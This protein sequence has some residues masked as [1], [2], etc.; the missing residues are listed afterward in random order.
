MHR[1]PFR[2]QELRVINDLSDSDYQLL[3]DAALGADGDD[4]ADM[5]WCHPGNADAEQFGSGV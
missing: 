3:F 4:T 1:S 2:D 5:G